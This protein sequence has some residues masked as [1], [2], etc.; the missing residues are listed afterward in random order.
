MTNIDTEL[1]K[2]RSA[3]KSVYEHFVENLTEGVEEAKDK[4]EKRLKR[5]IKDKPGAFHK[6]LRSVV[7]KNGIHKPKKGKE[8]NLNML[9]SSFLTDNIDQHFKQTFPNDRKSGPFYKAVHSFSLDTKRIDESEHVKLLHVFVKKEQEKLKTRL[10]REIC[11]RKKAIYNTLTETVEKEMKECYKKAAQ[12]TGKDSL[13]N[14]R[15]TIM[16][17]VK[18]QKNTMFDLATASFLAQLK[19]LMD[20]TEGT[21]DHELKTSV[22]VS[23]RKDITSMPDITLEFKSVEEYYNKFKL[24]QQMASTETVDDVVQE[25]P[26]QG[27]SSASVKDIKTT[28]GLPTSESDTPGQNP[29]VSEKNR[30]KTQPNRSPVE[31]LRSLRPEFVENVTEPVLKQLL[32]RL[33]Q[34]KII[35]RQ[36]MESTKKKATRADKARDVIDG[37]MRKGARASSF[38]IKAFCELDPSSDLCFKLRG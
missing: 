17:H 25:D 15:N 19:D 16:D 35:N 38:L 13:S 7:K 34:Q 31:K 2:V 10:C 8:I 30:T 5:Q 28:L 33:F 29:N 9:L 20:H 21:L 14:M 3:M 23:L 36:E 11:D 32:D 6:T 12:I 18:V 24:T 4:W 1:K 27:T 26:E 37:V 22:Q